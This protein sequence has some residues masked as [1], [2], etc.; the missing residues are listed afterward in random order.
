MRFEPGL[1]CGL[2]PTRDRPLTASL[3]RPYERGW[4]NGFVGRDLTVSMSQSPADECRV[5]DRTQPVRSDTESFVRRAADRVRDGLDRCASALHRLIGGD[6]VPL[7]RP[8]SSRIG[9][10]HEKPGSE[11]ASLVVKT[12][13]Q[14]HSA[15][16]GTLLEP[17]RRLARP[18]R[19]GADTPYTG[20]ELVTRID[21]EELTLEL[22]DQPGATITSDVWE[23]VER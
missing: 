15:R 11:R 3:T 7:D 1:Y 2:N 10:R 19:D 5:S 20:P 17:D 18:P 16:D 8:D 14:A 22:P 23:R 12:S 4:H 21:G 13:E 9:D 6:I